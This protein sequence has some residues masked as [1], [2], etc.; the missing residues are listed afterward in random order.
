MQIN[1]Q[2]TKSLKDF[3]KVIKE[4]KKNKDKSMVI[5][6]YRMGQQMMIG[7]KIY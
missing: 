7:S 5:H 4:H 2:E 3:E 1:D 6:I